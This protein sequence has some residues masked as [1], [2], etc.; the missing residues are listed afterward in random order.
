[1]YKGIQKPVLKIIIFDDDFVKN[2]DDFY[3]FT[4][5]INDF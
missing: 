5:F 2:I 4:F 3:D 1:M